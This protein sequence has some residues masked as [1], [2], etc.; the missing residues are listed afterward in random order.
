[1]KWLGFAAENVSYRK[2]ENFIELDV[3]VLYYRSAVVV[4]YKGQYEPKYWVD[5]RLKIQY[6]K[7]RKT[8]I[9]YNRMSLKRTN[10]TPIAPIFFSPSELFIILALIQKFRWRFTR[11]S[12]LTWVLLNFRALVSNSLNT[13]WKASTQRRWDNTTGN[14]SK[15]THDLY[16]TG[17]VLYQL[18]YQAIWELVTLWVSN[19]PVDIEEY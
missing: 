6:L 15:S 1:M 13:N 12:Y 18:S 8:R 4:K 19:V 16:D 10:I 3:P 9:A 2:K 5:G 11:E 7:N 17:A 14:K